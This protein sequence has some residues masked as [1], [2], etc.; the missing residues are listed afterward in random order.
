VISVA[1]EEARVDAVVTGIVDDVRKRGDVALCD[2]SKRFD[3]FDLTPGGIRL[4]ANEIKQCVAF[5][6]S[7]MV[8]VL[9]KAIQNIRDFHEQQV[10]DSWEYY[11]GDG[12][13]LGVRNTAI[14]RV[15]LYVPGGKAAY[16][17]SI[18]MNAIPAQVAGVERIVVVTPPKF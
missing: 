18:L 11:A 4:T 8:D 14:N 5:A 13:R 9:K 15:G 10:E 17:S 12:V 16:P 3:E 2:Y 1:A 7:G 6:D